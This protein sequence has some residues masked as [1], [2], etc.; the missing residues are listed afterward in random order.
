MTTQTIERNDK[1]TPAHRIVSQA[2]WLAARKP[3]L[4]EEKEFTRRRDA[5][6]AKRREI[7][8]GKVEK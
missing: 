2:E 1:K 5:L 3:F 4:A 7:P 6:G 8:W